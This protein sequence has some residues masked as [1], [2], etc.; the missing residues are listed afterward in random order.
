MSRELRPHTEFPELAIRDDQ[1]AQGAQTLEGLVAVLL[2]L[3]LL[4]RGIGRRQFLGV[5]VL[6]LPDEILQQVAIVLGQQQV[7]C[8]RDDLP[9]VLDELLALGRQLPR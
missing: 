5:K 7:L 9:E 8:L 2:G 1:G 3:L 4:D 6:G